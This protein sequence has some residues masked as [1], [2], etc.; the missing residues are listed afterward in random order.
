MSIDSLTSFYTRLSALAVRPVDT[1]D[2]AV[3]VSVEIL[4]LANL[5]SL[6]R[7]TP[8]TQSF[9]QSVIDQN[10]SDKIKAVQRQVLAKQPGLHD[11]FTKI[12]LN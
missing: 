12:K 10:R 8:G 7:Q 5:N 2:K 6:T 1:I 11:G 3:E 4:D 9:E